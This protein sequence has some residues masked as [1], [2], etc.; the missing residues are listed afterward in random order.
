MLLVYSTEI[1]SIELYYKD[2]FSCKETKVCQMNK[3]C[4]YDQKTYYHTTI[5][6]NS[7][8]YKYYF[9]IKTENDFYF[10][11]IYN[12][13]KNNYIID[14]VSFG[15]S[16]SYA[17]IEN[18]FEIS[19]WYL[20]T[21]WYQIFPDRYYYP[22]LNLN[23]PT[24]NQ[25]N[26]K[27][28]NNFGG[29]LK[30]I[31]Q[32]LSYIRSLGFNGIYLTP[33]FKSQSNHGYDTLDHM[34][35][36]SNFGSEQDL[37][38]LIQTA[39][40]LKIHIM[41][42]GV[43]NHISKYSHQWMDVINNK[44]DS[45]YYNWFLINDF[46]QI[47]WNLNDAEFEKNYSF[48]TFAF[49]SDMPKLNLTNSKV[50]DYLF[51]AINKWTQLKIDGWRIDVANEIIFSF[52]NQFNKQIRKHNPNIIVIGEVWADANVWLNQKAWTGA[53]NYQL[54]LIILNYFKNF[55]LYDLFV[56]LNQIIVNY[57]PSQIHGM[58]NILSTHDTKRLFSELQNN[59]Y[60]VKI[61]FCLMYFFPGSPSVYYGEEIN[62]E[63]YDDPDCRRGMVWKK[64]NEN[65]E[66]QQF[67]LKLNCLKTKIN[68]EINID[69]YLKIQ[70]KNKNLILKYDHNW[71]LILD[72]NQCLTIM[73]FDQII[74]KLEK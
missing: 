70:F 64:A 16:Y 24:W 6:L 49:T 74:F 53:M 32:K 2:P 35:I 37:L 66:M 22:N 54:R 15:F 57:T 50:C 26:L 34:I 25:T 71:I 17:A 30:G 43:F 48:E 20:Q 44:Q 23:D 18:Y 46:D 51:R 31:I 8:R 52:W 4:E 65:H 5:F 39:K 56:G 28:H 9:K 67:F 72:S 1:N 61:A 19:K 45:I 3:L 33:I 55:D 73:H 21:K 69:A 38:D 13:I 41:L 68:Y 63:G 7:H 47:N 42:D 14:E 11:G 27:N 12:T 40:E 62:M 58:Y 36:N 10:F 60:L 59:Q 29:N